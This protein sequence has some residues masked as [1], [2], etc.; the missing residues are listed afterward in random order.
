M[1]VS[2]ELVAHVFFATVGWQQLQPRLLC[3]AAADTTG[4]A[5]VVPVANTFLPVAA[6]V[7]ANVAVLAVEAALVGAWAIASVSK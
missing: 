7:A 3:S 5:V 4:V 6:N 1:V 2:F